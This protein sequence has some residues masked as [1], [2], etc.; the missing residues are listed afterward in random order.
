MQKVLDLGPVVNDV[1]LDLHVV[2]RASFACLEDIQ[3]D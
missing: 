1:L 3:F 2:L